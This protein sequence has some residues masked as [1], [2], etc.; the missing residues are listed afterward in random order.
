MS[1]DL[2]NT[3]DAATGAS[4]AALRTA[5]GRGARRGPELGPQGPDFQ[6]ALRSV[7]ERA[8][9]TA[10][11]S[12]EGSRP[13]SVAA[14][15]PAGPDTD[16]S[17]W[18]GSFA[19]QASGLAPA[20]PVPVEG[21]SA[22][23]AAML[24]T[25][26]GQAVQQD[27][28]QPMPGAAADPAAP[29]SSMPVGW[30][31]PTG[32]ALRSGP[33][34]AAAELASA[35][36]ARMDSA[37]LSSG[38]AD[39]PPAGAVVASN[40]AAPGDADEHSGAAVTTSPGRWL[41][42]EGEN[43]DPWGRDG[44]GFA[45]Q[46]ARALSDA[47]DGPLAGGF[48]SWGKELGLPAGSTLGLLPGVRG[49]VGRS[50][51]AAFRADAQALGLEVV[52]APGL[53]VGAAAQLPGAGLGSARGDGQGSGRLN[54]GPPGASLMTGSVPP[55]SA[56][57][58]EP[59]SSSLSHAGGPA[60]ADTENPAVAVWLADAAPVN[61]RQVPAGTAGF[62]HTRVATTESLAEQV[63]FHVFQGAH[64][65]EIT[66]QGVG[67]AAVEL[68]IELRGNQTSVEFRT[69][70]P[71]ARQLLE[72]TASDLQDMLERQGLVLSAVA[73]GNSGGGDHGPGQ[74][75]D[76]RR[77]TAPLEPVTGPLS[78][79]QAPA[80]RGNGLVDLYV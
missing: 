13:D 31:A 12:D 57:G 38:R 25:T 44:R 48:R 21:G 35:Q 19:A 29:G 76:F 56:P 39:R 62:E 8:Q 42:V 77:R 74:P 59:F 6:T 7:E 53:A 46:P 79:L 3:A 24:S 9:R 40:L 10:A 70:N 65:A 36:A 23:Q 32:L 30:P 37:Q 50:A 73:V 66:L 4:N 55:N 43:P 28:A 67:A 71:E 2:G 80:P 75:R 11:A 27:L 1:V 15:P 22:A 26:Q 20:M 51:A 60:Q 72:N 16:L 45:R 34:A 69:D 18:I 58:V 41:P 17:G 63:S 61:A 54:L 52:Q 78:A 64:R 68:R 14:E 47:G 33:G 5:D 49:A